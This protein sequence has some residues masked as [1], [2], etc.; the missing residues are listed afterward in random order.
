MWNEAE[1]MMLGMSWV[2]QLLGLSGVLAARWNRSWR[3]RRQCDLLA[4]MCVALVGI[5][6]LLL[7]R[8]CS[9]CWLSFATT[10]PLMAVGATLDFRKSTGSAAF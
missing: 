1:S 10:M 8:T 4:V 7:M 3:N 2:V 6:C 9:G 5:L